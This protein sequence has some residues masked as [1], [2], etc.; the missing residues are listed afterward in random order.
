MHSYILDRTYLLHYELLMSGHTTVD[1]SGNC[2]SAN[3]VRSFLDL[4]TRADKRNV[5]RVGRQGM[6]SVIT[7]DIS[8]VAKFL[9]GIFAGARSGFHQRF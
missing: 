2:R 1:V 8:E 6:T 7:M 5:S 4:T 9:C 3:L